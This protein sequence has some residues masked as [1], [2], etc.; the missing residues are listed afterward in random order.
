MDALGAKAANEIGAA[1]KAGDLD[2]VTH[3]IAHA[4]LGGAMAA[5]DGKDAASGALGAVVGVTS[6]KAEYERYN[7]TID[8]SLAAVKNFISHPVDG[9][10]KT[11]SNWAAQ[12]GCDCP[13]EIRAESSPGLPPQRCIF[14]VGSNRVAKEKGLKVLSTLSP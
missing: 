3:K 6:K 5:A 9:L 10:T 7:Q 12:L 4:A 1:A 11:Y 14:L 13:R 8:G 2:Y